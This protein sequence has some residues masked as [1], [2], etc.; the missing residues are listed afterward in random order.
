MM[1]K[2]RFLAITLSLIFILSGCAS[3][4]KSETANDYDGGAAPSMTTAAAAAPEKDAAPENDIQDG[5]AVI[6]DPGN[7][8]DS[9]KKII[10]TVSISME[11]ED[12]NKAISELGLK[13]AALGGYVSDSSYNKYEN[14]ASGTITVRIPPDKLKEFT[15]QVGK[16]GE[17]LSSSMGSQDVT[18]DY[19]DVQSRLTNAL[20]QEAQL[21]EIMAKAVKIEDILN[22]RRELDTVQSEIESLKGQ[23][24]LMDNL[25]GYSTV[26]ISITQPTPPPTSPD[27]DANSG[28]LARWSFDYIW[29]SV[30]KGFS[31]SLSF[32]VNAIGV[33]FIAISYLIIPAIIVGAIII[34]II[35]V[36]KR[37]S[38]KKIQGKTP[39]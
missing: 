2:I 11:A 3:S 37:H 28:L 29:N 22:V 14:S 8:A 19:V 10:Y 27:P 39:K 6:I 7:I 21:L 23:I 13:A 17:V 25:V 4:S 38:K 15:E 9:G 35:V 5:D 33:I 20:A 1:K 24:R 18:A 26:M 34:V 12:A 32:T 31:N 30:Q 16:V 36:V